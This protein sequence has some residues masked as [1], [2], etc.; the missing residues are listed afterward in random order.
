MFSFFFFLTWPAPLQ[1]SIY[2]I[3]RNSVENMILTGKY[4][5]NQCVGRQGLIA[6]G[7]Q[8]FEPRGNRLR[9]HSYALGGARAHISFTFLSLCTLIHPLTSSL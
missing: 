5:K 7:K 6:R 1:I 2:R 8:H 9:G 3:E 4:L